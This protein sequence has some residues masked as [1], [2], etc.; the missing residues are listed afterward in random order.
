V[1]GLLIGQLAVNPNGFKFSE[2]AT[3]KILNEKTFKSKLFTAVK[4]ALAE[5][6]IREG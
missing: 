6:L 3:A 1:E 5:K 4:F 2:I